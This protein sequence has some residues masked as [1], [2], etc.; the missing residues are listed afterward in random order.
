MSDVTKEKKSKK[1]KDV[2]KAVELN[3]KIV[4][5]PYTGHTPNIFFTD[6]LREM[7]S[8]ET[9]KLR[10]KARKFVRRHIVNIRLDGVQSNG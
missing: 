5:I 7:F 9:K 3:M 6:K 2:S 4:H 8:G 10:R 1:Q